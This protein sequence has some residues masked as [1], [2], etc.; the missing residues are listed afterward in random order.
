[1]EDIST[2]IY[3]RDAAALQAPA[4]AVEATV[5][6]YVDA[7]TGVYVTI[8]SFDV[9]QRFGPCRFVGPAPARGDACLVVFDEERE[10]WVIVPGL[11]GGGATGPAGPTGATGAQGPAGVAGPV[12]A[13]GPQ[14]P[15]GATGAAGAAGLTWR[16]DWTTTDTY[17]TNDAVYYA[18]SSYRATAPITAGGPPPGTPQ[19]VSFQASGWT[20]PRTCTRIASG[21]TTAWSC[22][23]GEAAYAYFFCDV[24]VGGTLT[25]DKE[26][27]PNGYMRIYNA[28]GT[29]VYAGS[30]DA[31]LTVTAQR[32]YIRIEGNSVANESGTLRLVPGTAT[33][34]P[35]S[36][37]TLVAQAGSSDTYIYTQV[38]PAT[39]WSITHNLNRWPAVEVVDSG[40][41]VII[42]DVLY[43]NANSL[44]VSFGSATSGKAYL[45]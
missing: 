45:N 19:T 34:T 42:P 9:G 21:V 22:A 31:A 27:L 39:S 35:G 4:T 11:A 16:G 10:P 29:Q 41:T 3:G 30:S 43:V 28:A 18:G 12:G 36:A 44:T 25:F 6:E 32:Y 5:A 14:G 17:A 8:P 2:L 23:T 38:S 15:T 33:V 20:A 24:S 7:A 37:W 40:G 13:T 26:V 1:M